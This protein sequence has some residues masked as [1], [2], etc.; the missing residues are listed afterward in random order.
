MK[1][2]VGHF[3][4]RKVAILMKS[5]LSAEKVLAI[6]EDDNIPKENASPLLNWLL[7]SY[8]D[9]TNGVAKDMDQAVR[10]YKM[11]N[12]DVCNHFFK[13]I[14]GFCDKAAERKDVQS[15]KE[16]VELIPLHNY[17]EYYHRVAK[18]ILEQEKFEA[19]VKKAKGG[20]MSAALEVARRSQD[21]EVKRHW[22]AEHFR[23][24]PTQES[25]NYLFDHFDSSLG[26]DSRISLWLHAKRNEKIVLSS[27]QERKI[28]LGKGA[29]SCRQTA[30]IKTVDL[31][32]PTIFT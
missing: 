22:Y 21:P 27:A 28:N 32:V 11:G 17:R 8:L 13:R 25:F 26:F 2:A 1:Q 31:R 10:V 20:D 4:D 5:D 3:Y 24:S 12:A 7:D 15:L 16:L 30:D 9:G 19:L 29:F 23:H 18:G 6:F 14:V